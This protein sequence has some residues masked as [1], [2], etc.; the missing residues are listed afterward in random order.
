MA[1]SCDYHLFYHN[2]TMQADRHSHFTR[3]NLEGPS[4]TLA[5]DY[6][7]HMHESEISLSCTDSVELGSANVHEKST[8][9]TKI[10]V[11]C[12]KEMCAM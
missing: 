8:M 5:R 3:L 6:R 11:D 4:D 1:V 10:Y 7:K 12:W 2:C 9:S